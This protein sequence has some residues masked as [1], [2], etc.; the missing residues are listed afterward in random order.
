[1]KD[2]IIKTTEF[3]KT[4]SKWIK[5]HNFDEYG[6][7]CYMKYKDKNKPINGFIKG[8]FPTIFVVDNNNRSHTIVLHKL[9]SPH[10]EIDHK[11]FNPSNNSI[12][13]LQILSKTDNILKSCTKKTIVTFEDGEEKNFSSQIECAR[14]FNVQIYI[15]RY[16]VNHNTKIKKL[17]ISKIISLSFKE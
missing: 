5:N 12:E 11:D 8:K 14:Y 1:M 2:R 16:A 10:E 6:R 9:L 4:H 13:N 17:N 15:I 7:P 3:Y